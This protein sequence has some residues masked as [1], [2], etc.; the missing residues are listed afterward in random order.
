MD[1]LFWKR[2]QSVLWKFCKNHMKIALDAMG[3]DYAPKNTI[4]GAV[5]ALKE[6]P[7]IEELVLVGNTSAI[8]TE[9]K[10]AGYE[11][12]RINIVHATEVVDMD[13]SAARAIRQ[14]KDASIS[15]AIDLVKNGRVQ[16]MVSAG[17]TGAAVAASVLKLRTLKGV[18]RPA[19]A[20]IL[21]TERKAFVLIDAGANPNSE[22]DNLLQFAIMGSVYARYVLDR[23]NPS[24]GLLSIGEE[25]TTGNEITKEAS[26]LLKRT[27][28]NFQGNIE[29]SDL[30]EK[31]PDVVVCD[32]FTG[33]VLLKTAEAAALAIFASLKRQ[34]FK[35]RIRKLGALLVKDAFITIRNRLN[36]DAYG[37]SQLLGVNGTCIIAHGSSSP[38]AIK[39]AIRAAAHAIQYELNPHII[40][41]I[42]KYELRAPLRG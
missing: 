19:V 34:L 20:C 29:G 16:A 42:Q 10:R 24:I 3:G 13:E 8:E 21:P 22:A 7:L 37:G 30:F 35:S 33:N 40:E 2:Y 23:G 25:D 1:A 38:V 11:D 36:P 18:E 6:F 26:K 17:H 27:A 9:L 5:L 41:E 15:R 4:E 14:K 32:G 12:A 28:L 31:P 39:N